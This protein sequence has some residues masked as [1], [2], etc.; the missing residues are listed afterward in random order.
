MHHFSA[1][2][3]ICHRQNNAGEKFL[4]EMR[5]SGKK[6]ILLKVQTIQFCF[7]GAWCFCSSTVSLSLLMLIQS[8]NLF[9]SLAVP[10]YSDED[11]EKLKSQPKGKSVWDSRPLSDWIYSNAFHVCN[12]QSKHVRYARMHTSFHQMEILRISFERP[13]NNQYCKYSQL[14]QY[15]VLLWKK[16]QSC[17]QHRQLWHVQRAVSRRE[18]LRY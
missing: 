18:C 7:C 11:G 4:E 17:V 13:M 15:S 1:Q 6:G 16:K 3:K 9:T 2:L 12:G 5:V 8:V 14:I 10:S